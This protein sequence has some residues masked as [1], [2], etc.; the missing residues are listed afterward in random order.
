MKPAARKDPHDWGAQQNYAAPP[1]YPAPQYPAV[2]PESESAGSTVAIH[3][4][5]LIGL[6]VLGT[7][8]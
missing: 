6:A 7:Y 8:F 2:P 1:I 3:I 4:L 5:R